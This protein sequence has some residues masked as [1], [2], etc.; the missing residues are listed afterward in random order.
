MEF[1]NVQKKSRDLQNKIAEL[2]SLEQSTEV[3]QEIHEAEGQLDMV[4]KNEE[5]M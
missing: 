5:S 3:I 1:G 4:L 2:Q